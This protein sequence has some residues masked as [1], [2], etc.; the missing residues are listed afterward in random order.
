MQGND[1]QNK[2]KV[3]VSKVNFQFAFEANHCERSQ[4][5]GK[6]EGAAMK[7]LL[8]KLAVVAVILVPLVWA[9]PGQSQT[10]TVGNAPISRPYLDPYFDFSGFSYS[11]VTVVDNANLIPLDGKVTGFQYYAANTTPFRFILV[12]G[13]HDVVKW[14]SGEITPAGTDSGNS[15]TTY[16]L[17]EPY[18]QVKSGW[19]IGVYLMSDSANKKGSSAIPFDFDSSGNS[20][21]ISCLYNKPAPRFGD[22]VESPD[23]SNRI[24]SFRATL[25]PDAP[26]SGETVDVTIVKYLDGAHA[27]DSVVSA[28]GNVFPMIASWGDPNNS[29]IGGTDSFYLDQDGYNTSTPYEAKSPVMPMGSFYSVAEDTHQNTVRTSCDGE[30]PFSRLLGYTTGDTLD[31]ALTAA[32]TATAP[33]WSNNNLLANKYVIVWN[34]TCGYAKVTVVKYLDGKHA[35]ATSAQSKSFPMK[36]SYGSGSVPFALGPSGFNTRNSYEAQSRA[37]ASGASYSVSED[38]SDT[39][40]SAVGTT[41]TSGQFSRL[42]GYTTG[43]TLQQAI[44]AARTTTTPNLTNITGNQYVIVWNE[45]CKPVKVTVVKYL[46]GNKA[47]ATTA[48]SNAFPM[49]ASWSAAN[50]SGSKAFVLG[51]AGVDTANPYEAQSVEMTSG[52]SYGISEDTSTI[53][54]GSS[55][56]NGQFS[57]LLGYTTGD[58]LAKAITATRTATAPNLTN[59]VSN[60]YAIVWNGTC[61]AVPPPD[62]DDDDCDHDDNGH[63]YGND[64]GDN[65]KSSKDKDDDKKGKDGG[66]R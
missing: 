24:Y 25:V 50:G 59:I 10:I 27:S 3:R 31:Q 39:S 16:S 17:A 51:P 43:N 32:R 35:D 21:F 61:Q 26:Q 11:T 37:M 66:K 14:V 13:D 33:S 8:M 12:D 15:Y 28:G 58:T 45:T 38:T 40:A 62:D 1:D 4:D 5:E 65:H 20:G 19:Y 22:S 60:Q 63:H 48:K 54:V 6:R 23:R 55:C 30:F 29:T 46:D 7:K 49:N 41:C 36:E 18:P 9:V 64:K 42:L 34:E 56:A 2:M 57:Q 47:D 53:A 44:T 52:A